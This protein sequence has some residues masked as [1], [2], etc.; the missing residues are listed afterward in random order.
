MA[1]VMAV[2]TMSHV[3][4]KRK[5]GPTAS[6]VSTDAMASKKAP[7]NCPTWTLLLIYVVETFSY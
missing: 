7:W 4:E 3:L 2:M 6:H 5:Y 1:S